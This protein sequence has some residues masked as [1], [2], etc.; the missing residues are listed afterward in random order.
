MHHHEE[1]RERRRIEV[2]WIAFI[3]N[4]LTVH[5]KILLQCTYL[6]QSNDILVYQSRKM[7]RKKRYYYKRLSSSSSTGGAVGAVVVEIVE[8]EEEV[9][10]EATV[11][12]LLLGTKLSDMVSAL[13]IFVT[14]NIT[15]MM[16]VRE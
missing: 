3:N 13:A 6:H 1:K 16:S 8:E 7:K 14:F 15:L 2:R 12:I 11:P 10:G 9:G 5:I 4:H